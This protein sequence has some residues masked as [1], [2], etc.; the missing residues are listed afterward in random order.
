MQLEDKELNLIKLFACNV[1]HG[2]SLWGNLNFN[3]I[4]TKIPTL[5]FVNK[6][7]TISFAS[8]RGEGGDRV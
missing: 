2:F 4:E 5:Y 8:S 1:L 6:L 3:F 7:L